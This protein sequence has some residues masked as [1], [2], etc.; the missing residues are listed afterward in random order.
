MLFNID[1]FGHYFLIRVTD[2]KT[3]LFV[4]FKLQSCKY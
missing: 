3:I 2:Y 1:Y 4:L